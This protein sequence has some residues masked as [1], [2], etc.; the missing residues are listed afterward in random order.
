LLGMPVTG[1]ALG[2]VSRPRA[3]RLDGNAI[4]QPVAA[5]IFRAL[6]QW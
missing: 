6:T 3:L 5:V 1:F 4:V 2:A